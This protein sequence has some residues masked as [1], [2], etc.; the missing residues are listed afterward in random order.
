M[1]DPLADFLTRIRNAGLRRMKQVSIPHS[2]LKEEMAKILVREGFIADFTIETDEKTGFKQ[3]L[4]TLRYAKGRFAIEHL[5]RVS[6]PGI[7]KYV[8][9]NE[10][11]KVLGG[12]GV[13]IVST[14][15]G[16]LTGKEAREK[17]VGGELL[18]TIY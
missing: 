16:V 1:T 15:Q 12:I 7:R 5:S 10:I 11:P 8:S 13:C 6:K 3:I 17:K 4:L 18:C 2:H 14:S 9:Y